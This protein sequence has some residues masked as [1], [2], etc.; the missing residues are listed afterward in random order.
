MI[1]GAGEKHVPVIKKFKAQS[2]YTIVAD[3]ASKASG[4]RLHPKYYKENLGK[5]IG[6]DLYGGKP[7]TNEDYIL[8]SR[9]SPKPI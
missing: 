9:V 4:I 5:K 8:L 1:L 3:Y 6:K 7:L 2:L